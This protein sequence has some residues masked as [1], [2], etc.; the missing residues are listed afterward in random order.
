MDGRLVLKNCSVFCPDARFRSAMAVLIERGKI[1]K[2][3][4]DD[5]IPIL[6]GDWE[7]SC[8]GRVVAP[9][10]V[11]CHAHLVGGQLVPSSAQF[12]LK[13]RRQ[14]FEAQQQIESKLVPAE[15][16]ALTAFAIARALRSGVTMTVEHLHCPSDAGSGLAAQSRTAERLGMR[17]VNSHATHSGGG[18]SLAMKQL[19]ANAEQAL[20]RK[21]HPLVRSALGFHA[22]FACDDALLS[23]LGRLR[24]ELGVGV[25]GHVA[26]SEEDV[27]RTLRDFGQRI[28]PRLD[29][30]GLLGRGCIAAFAS[31]IDRVESERLAK[32]GTVVALS[33]RRNSMEEP[34]AAGAESVALDEGLISLGTAG[35]TSLRDEIASAFASMIQWARLGRGLD[36]DARLGEFL[37]ATPAALCSGIFGEP[38][39]RVEPGHQ[40]D[41]VVY[42]LLSS[43]D[44]TAGLG[45]LLLQI[46]LSPV[47]W[48]I[49]AGRVVVRDGRLLA[50]D[51]HQLAK[52]AQ[53]AL[54]SVR[55]R[56]G[57]PSA[58]ALK[59]GPQPL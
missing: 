21:H 57:A 28:V 2:V 34:A 43:A 46:A 44:G 3:A 31:A 52:D 55:S 59:S 4:P 18:A 50:H 41:L 1:S 8:H 20:E 39:G 58:P 16:E 13:P 54:E 25:H 37:L 45:G 12:L 7:V 15:V 19:E 33:P 26:E 29:A 49:V 56:A 32:S 11:D 40:A 5:E 30:H 14:R 47:A 38:S 23:R 51:F 24:G 17:F 36:P 35:S 48:T 9:G 10:L 22:S 27:A 53:R 42:D 6:P